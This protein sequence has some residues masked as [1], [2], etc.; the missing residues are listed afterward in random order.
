[1]TKEYAENLA[2]IA[3]TIVGYAL[4]HERVKKLA[5]SVLAKFKT[6][7]VF[8]R[9]QIQATIDNLR[10]RLGAEMVNIWQANNG[11]YSMADFPFKYL[12]IIFESYDVFAGKSVKSN[13]RNSPVE[14]W[15]PLLLAIQKSNRYFVGTDGSDI[16]ILRAAYKAF[17]LKMGI[18]YK[19]D[20]KDVYMGFLSVA[21]TDRRELTPE[22]IADIEATTIYVYSLIHKL[23][24]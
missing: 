14:D 10:I 12:N 23:K 4:T 20:N 3:I 18:D 8:V 5:K 11:T 19:F 9:E 6:H 16:G 22:E 13:F 2:T 17:G 24:R 15:L 7:D 1:M 21:F